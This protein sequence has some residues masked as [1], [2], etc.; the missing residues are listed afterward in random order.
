M[1]NE[2]FNITFRIIQ[3][4]KLLSFVIIFGNDLRKKKFLNFLMKTFFLNFIKELTYKIY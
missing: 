4:A 1:T 2:T 3:T